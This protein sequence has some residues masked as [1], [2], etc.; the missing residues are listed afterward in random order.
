LSSASSAAP[1]SSQAVPIKRDPGVPNGDRAPLP[2]ARLK[3]YRAPWETFEMANETDS[4]SFKDGDIVELK[5]GG[6]AMTVERAISA[7]TIKCVW[8]DASG[9]LK[10]DQFGAS[11]LKAVTRSPKPKAAS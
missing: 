1:K 10:R 2:S 8:F 3:A 5:S 4:G 9:A 11:S 7:S 6:P